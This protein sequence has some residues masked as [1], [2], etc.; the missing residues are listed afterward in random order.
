[1]LVEFPLSPSLSIDETL[2]T[3]LDLTPVRSL[4]TIETRFMLLDTTRIGYLD[5]MGDLIYLLFI[6]P[7]LD[8]TTLPTLGPTLNMILT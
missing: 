5:P 4:D 6:G 3:T 7:I 8:P 2:D 1:M